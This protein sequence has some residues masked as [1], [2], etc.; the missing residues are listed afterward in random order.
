MP[1]RILAL[2]PS[3]MQP[4]FWLEKAGASA[5]WVIAAIIFGNVV[6]FAGRAHRRRGGRS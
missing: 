1:A 6:F 4:E 2:G 5:A 3:F